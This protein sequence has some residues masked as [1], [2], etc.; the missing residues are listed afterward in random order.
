[1]RSVAAWIGQAGSSPVSLRKLT[2]AFGELFGPLAD[3]HHYFG[4]RVHKADRMYFKDFSP[5]T[6]FGWRD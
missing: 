5:V 4:S 1:V 6:F 2:V 3:T